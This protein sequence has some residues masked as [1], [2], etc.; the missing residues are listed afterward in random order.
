M[1]LQKYLTTLTKTRF[2]F[3][4]SQYTFDQK[5]NWFQLINN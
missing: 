2:Q 4:Y 1:A 3:E 5:Q